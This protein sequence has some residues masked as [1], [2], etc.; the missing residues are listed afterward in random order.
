MSR[1][2][3]F[4]MTE[5]VGSYPAFISIN[6]LPEGL[7]SITVRGTPKNGVEGP[8]ATIMLTSEQAD[9]LTDAMIERT[10]TDERLDP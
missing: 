1:K 2:N 9:A 5:P 8:Q 3:I 6:A 10:Y 7:V 4:A